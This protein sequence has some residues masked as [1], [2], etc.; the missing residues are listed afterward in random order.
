MNKESITVSGYRFEL[1]HG[2]AA[3]KLESVWK[4][5]QNQVDSLPAFLSW[6]W[7]SCWISTYKPDTI[8]V[9]GYKFGQP[10]CAGL[11]VL[12]LEIRHLFIRSRQLRLNQTGIASEDQIWVEY[13]D[14]LCVPEHREEASIA[15]LKAA[16]QLLNWDELVISMMQSERTALLTKAFP[17]SR[18]SMRSARFS[19]D[20]TS[21]DADPD[22]YLASLSSNTRYQIRRSLRLYEKKYGAI[23]LEV[24]G[25]TQQALD[26]LREAGELHKQRWSDSGFLNPQFVRFHENL[27]K[28]S[29]STGF[30]TLLRLKAGITTLAIIYY[31]VI[32][33]I[34]YFYLHGLRY[35]KDPKFKPGLVAHSMAIS[36]FKN[37]QLDRYDFM[38]GT[39]QYKTQLAQRDTPLETLIIERPLSRFWL[40]GVL[41]RVKNR[42]IHSP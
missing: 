16:H 31:Q 29:F 3:Q 7:I 23:R 13:N 9:I 24:P 2:V 36:H 40:E 15:C 34:A 38:G 4:H 18:I 32:D 27:I 11:F 25:T 21:L 35:E 5:I 10:V 33:G 19:V 14:L 41:R 39:N 37:L 8:F 1:I 6:E 28:A 20:L 12:S 22:A 17:R 26:F 42:I 30:T